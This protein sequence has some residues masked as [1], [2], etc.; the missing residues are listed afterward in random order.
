MRYNVPLN[1]VFRTSLLTEDKKAKPIVVAWPDTVLTTSDWSAS[2]LGVAH[3]GVRTITR[4][5]IEGETGI[6][7][8]TVDCADL[9]A[10]TVINLKGVYFIDSVRYSWYAE[11]Y[12]D[13]SPEV[14]NIPR[15]ATP[16]EGGAEFNHIKVI[17][18]ASTFRERFS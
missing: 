18:S 2:I 5:I 16:I 9:V 3:L 11:V 15:L 17:D 12:V 13:A 6:H 14:S 8:L 1:G 10:G 7:N 4:S